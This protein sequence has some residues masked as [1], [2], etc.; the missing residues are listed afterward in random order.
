MTIKWDEQFKGLQLFDQVTGMP[1][2]PWKG[3]AIGYAQLP[4]S[5]EV[6]DRATGQLVPCTPARCPYATDV[7]NPFTGQS[8]L[9]NRAPYSG[10]A[11][12]NGMVNA[13]SSPASK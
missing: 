9:V 8:R 11:G 3:G 12:I 4:G 13:G 10:I 5:A 6:L 7:T 2:N 1:Y